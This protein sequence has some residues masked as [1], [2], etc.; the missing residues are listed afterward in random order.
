[1]SRTFISLIA[2][3]I[4]EEDVLKAASDLEEYMMSREYISR[5]VKRYLPTSPPRHMPG[6]QYADLFVRELCRNAYDEVF[7]GVEIIATKRIRFMD[8][9]Q[10]GFSVSCPACSKKVDIDT[11]QESMNSFF[12]DGA[13]ELVCPDCKHKG[14][15]DHWTYTPYVGF[16]HLSVTFWNTPLLRDEC[17]RELSE[18]VGCPLLIVVGS[19]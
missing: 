19:L 8:N 10:N 15:V 12:H 18:V 3:D 14:R 7:N 17:L 1:M 9:G 11:W 6:P 2:P 5:E 13:G 4:S 16:S